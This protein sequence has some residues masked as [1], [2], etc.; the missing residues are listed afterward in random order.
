[1]KPII[2]LVAVS[3]LFSQATLANQFYRFQVDGKTVLEDHLPAEHS[4][5]GY[6]VLNA[7]GMVIEVVAPAPTEE[8][9]AAKAKQEA[10]QQAREQAVAD[11]KKEDMTLLR[12]YSQPEDV[13]RARQRKILELDSYIQLQRRNISDLSQKLE[14][15]H[16]RAANIERNG[17]EVP[18]NIRT[19]I[20]QLQNGIKDS[21]RNIR[22]RQAA[23]DELTQE[24]AQQYERVR[25]LQVYQPGVLPE[26]VDLEHVDR[27]LNQ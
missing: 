27:T 6:E 17:N 4:K 15:E 22:Q 9:L 16:N 23:M 14:V 26:D 5:L 20:I 8:E 24:M 1:M 3:L 7:R 25:I 19:N 18:A 12:L 13:E 2:G 11:Q 21:E 10:I